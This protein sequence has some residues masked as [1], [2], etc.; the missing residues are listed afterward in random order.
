M[1]QSNNHGEDKTEIHDDP[2]V[3]IEDECDK[4]LMLSSNEIF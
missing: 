4:L 3:I 1:D 2:E